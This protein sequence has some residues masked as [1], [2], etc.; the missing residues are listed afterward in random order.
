MTIEV[1]KRTGANLIETVDAVKVVVERLKRTWPEGVEVTLHAG[2]VQG[3]PPDAGRPAELGRDRRAAG[4]RDH[5]VRA[6]LPR[7]A[8]H[9]HRDPGLVPRRRARPAAWPGSP[10]TSW[11]CSRSSSRSACWW[12]MPSSSRNSP[13]AAWPRACRRGGLFAR[14]QAHVG[15][16]DRRDRDARRGV[17]AA[18]VLARRRRRVH[19]IP[20][21]HADRDARRPRWSW[22]WCSRRRSAP[23]SARRRRCRMTSAPP[24]RGP[25]MRTVR[26]A[27]RHPGT[28]LALAAFLLVAVQVAYGKFGRGVEFFPN[29]EPDYGQVDRACARQPRARREEPPGRRGREARAGV[30]RP[31]DGLH[32]DRRAAAR[33]RARSPKTRSA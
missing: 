32:P 14:R 11:C 29:V 25:Y 30:R 33:D 3:H 10:S 31:Q 5:P 20:A 16:G 26:L 4:G 23:C 21:D 17:L 13:S 7:L 24:T 18:P 6:R 27:L 9:R 8:V 28:T 22:R 1:S 2:Q 15:P 12:T 19:E